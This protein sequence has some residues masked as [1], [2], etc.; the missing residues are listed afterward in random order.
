MEHIVGHL[1]QLQGG[2]ERRMNV[3]SSFK[4]N[5]KFPSLGAISLFSL[6]HMCLLRLG[7]SLGCLLK[8]MSF[9]IEGL[10]RALRLLAK[11]ISW[12]SK[13]VFGE[14]SSATAFITYPHRGLTQ[15]AFES[16]EH[17]AKQLRRSHLP[18]AAGE[19]GVRPQGSTL[20]YI[21]VTLPLARIQAFICRIKIGGQ[22]FPAGQHPWPCNSGLFSG[23][24]R[25]RAVY[26]AEPR[27]RRDV[28]A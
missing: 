14:H 28:A 6:Q 12:V 9:E 17:V 3:F 25:S 23:M 18:P 13:Q 1:R 10:L 4:I 24:T 11:G 21:E 16:G 20:I 19:G 8:R 22:L 7:C 26:S 5:Q 15:P 2:A 27:Q